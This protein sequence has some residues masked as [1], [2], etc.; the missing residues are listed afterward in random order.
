MCVYC[1]CTCLDRV[2]KLRTVG[3]DDS[4]WDP[5]RLQCLD[6]AGPPAHFRPL[7]I[8]ERLGRCY[9]NLV[10]LSLMSGDSVDRMEK[11]YQDSASRCHSV[12]GS[13]SIVEE[14]KRRE[15][16]QNFHSSSK[17]STS[18]TSLPTH[19]D[20]NTVGHNSAWLRMSQ[21]R[22]QTQDRMSKAL[23][24]NNSEKDR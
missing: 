10:L 8:Q 13:T 2:Y 7:I 17:L 14:A 22:T 9:L 23:P 4:Q 11:G 16:L 21:D 18:F 24:R 6:F 12:P 1:G 19:P 3:H 15:G 20:N 5:R